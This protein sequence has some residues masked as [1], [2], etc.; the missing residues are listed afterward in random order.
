MTLFLKPDPT[1]DL[2]WGH[3]I[4]MRKMNQETLMCFPFTYCYLQI[5][6]WK[7]HIF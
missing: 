5:Q 4:L 7:I 2:E 3:F 1:I 6:G